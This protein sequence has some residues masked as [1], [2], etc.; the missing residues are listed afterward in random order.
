M[1]SAF[2]VHIRKIRAIAHLLLIHNYL[3]PL[4]TAH[5]HVPLSKRHRDAVSTVRVRK[6][7]ITPPLLKYSRNSDRCKQAM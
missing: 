7:S 2:L 3:T 4:L 6:V 1:V 5:P